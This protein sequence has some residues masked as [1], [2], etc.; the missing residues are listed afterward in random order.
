MPALGGTLGWVVGSVLR[1]RRRHV[2]AAL[3]RAGLDRSGQTARD[4]YQSLGTTVF[5]LLWAAGRPD[6]SSNSLVHV[7]AWHRVEAVRAAGRGIVVATA[8]TGNWD[9]SACAMAERL[10]LTV[11]TKHLSWRSLDRFWQRLRA[12]RGVR[13]LDPEGALSHA[14]A[15]LAEGRAVTFLIDQAPLRD[16][17]VERS[18]FLG[19]T[20]QHD[21]VFALLAARCRV[22]IV[23]AFPLRRPDGTHEVTI[24]GVLEPPER[25]SR[26]WAA[27]AT[28]AAAAA[29]EQFVRDHPEQWLWLHRRWKQAPRTGLR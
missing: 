22:P 17:G 19:A 29:L 7:D 2:D 23:L 26:Q 24:A 3:A 10:P 1:I 4:V 15:H 13:L 9:L 21:A 6:S 27:S 16:R 18:S 11:V 12:R 20:A 25:P 28:R 8:H 14:R 5:E